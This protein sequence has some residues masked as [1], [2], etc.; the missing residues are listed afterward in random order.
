M[1]GTLLT[2]YIGEITMSVM[3]ATLSN[4]VISNPQRPF[5]SCTV[6]PVRQ[7]VLNNETMA[8][9]SGECGPICGAIIG[10]LIVAAI[11]NPQ[12]VVDA[13]DWYVDRVSEG[14]DVA[15]DFIED[16]ADGLVNFSY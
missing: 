11:T 4:R 8:G 15:N 10:G 3:T 1:I 5:V 2:H 9:A 12:Q 16:M 14:I 13:V 7:S 6:L